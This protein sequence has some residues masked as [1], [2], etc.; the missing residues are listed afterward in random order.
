MVSLYPD[1]FN[2]V[3]GPIMQPGS[4][5]HFAAPCRIGLL[6]RSL[7]GEEP[8]EAQFI[9]AP[10]SSW[11]GT[12]G[13]MRED[14]GMLGGVLGLKP[15]DVGLFSAKEL[16]RGAGLRFDYRFEAVPESDHPNAL[17]IRL[18]GSSGRRVELVGDSTGGGMVE[19]RAI[20]G[21]LV[22]F[23]GDC[24]VLLAR[25]IP[26]QADASAISR[27]ESGLQG[28]LEGGRLPGS[29]N[30][31]LCFW[32]LSEKPD[33][34]GLRAG[35]RSLR[36]DL[37]EAILPVVSSA[38]KLPQLFDSMTAW[39]EIAQASGQSLFETALE[40]E[41]RS[42]GWGRDVVLDA[43]REIERLLWRQTHALYEEGPSFTREEF[44]RYDSEAWDRHSGAE[45]KGVSGT[46]RLAIRSAL[47]VVAKVP[48]VKIV[49]GPMG[50]G[51]GFLYS[52]LDAAR[53]VKKLGDEEVLRGLFIAA[54]V[55]AIAY[56]RAEPTG[57]MMGCAGE[58]GICSAMAA[59]AIAEASGGS[60]AA[61]EN[62]ASFA[63]QAMIGLPCD[64][65]P[66]GFEQPCFSRI[67]S[68][69]SNALVFSELALAG[70]DAVLPFHE[71][72]DAAA[73]VG[74][75]L[76]SE[77]RCTSKGGCCTTPTGQR[78]AAAFAAKARS[79]G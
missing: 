42:S 26:G 76:P 13:L 21:F 7:L 69:V 25:E 24:H 58:C 41:L 38:K 23:R 33:L 68:A 35:F 16:A 75:S 29:H 49:P 3:F 50:T 59:A 78:Q 55:G 71:A 64:P 65:I 10:E 43:M 2:D 28:L 19:C 79:R 8:A 6:A 77:L 30:A 53:T 56:T 27:I 12:F 48:G 22:S 36:L 66:G 44:G 34:E 20:D 72:L 60:P 51:G 11:A 70:S 67:V 52:A 9:M 63:L 37:L 73:R 74:R 14:F 62:A 17:K 18:A 54:G 32:K 5:S 31:S 40:Y 15:D 46:T 57:E 61:V 47:A 39:R 1:Y 45:D 4:S